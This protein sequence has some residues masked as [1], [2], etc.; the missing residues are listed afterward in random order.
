MNGN[1][2]Y[3]K[4]FDP[5]NGAQN[6]YW[7]STTNPDGTPIFTQPA[8]GT[9]VTEDGIRDV[10]HHPGLSNWNLGLFKKFAVTERFGFQFRAEA[11]NAFNHPNLSGVGLDPTNLT[12]FGKVTGKT[13][14]V[15]N[16]QLSL[17]A[18]F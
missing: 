9:F 12:T 8:K 1:P 2:Q 10:I 5:A 4:N 3:P 16:L 14:D 18:Y 17:R 15:R 11:F 13:D 6:Q 7:F